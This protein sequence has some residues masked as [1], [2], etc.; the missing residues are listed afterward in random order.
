MSTG[1]AILRETD[2]LP[3]PRRQWAIATIALGLI[4]AVMDSAIANVALPTIAVDLNSEPAHSIWVVNGYQLAI[5]V[6]LLPLSSL[7][8]RIGYRNIYLP[9]LAIFT[10]ASVACALSTSLPMLT[11]ARVIQGF[12]AAGIMSVNTALL[13]YIYPQR[14]LGRGIGINALVVALSAAAGPTIASAILSVANWPWLFAVNLPIGLVAL[15]IGMR[16]LPATPT[17]TH[18]FDYI[19]ALLSAA[20]FGLLIGSIDALAQGEGIGLFIIEMT[21]GIGLAWLLTKREM[22]NPAPVL[23]VDLLRIPI[24]ALSLATSISSFAA[25]MLALVSLPFMLHDLGYDA[26]ETG[27]LITPWPIAIAI[28]APLAGR[29]TEKYPAGLLGGIGLGIFA[30][31][32]L[33]LALIPPQPNAFDI[34]WRM[35]L[36]GA[37][38]GMFQSPNNRAIIMSAPKSRSGGASGM[39]GTARLLG[40]TTGAAMV[41]LLFSRVPVH[42]TAVALLMA[43][44]FAIVA[45]FVSF[46]RLYEGKELQQIRPSNPEADPLMRADILKEQAKSEPPKEP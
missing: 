37:G 7:G 18:K 9:G 39:L 22:G 14:L 2:G 11:L 30:V 15:L 23:P 31:G 27:L 33:S 10:L 1:E 20:T 34:I 42:A 6:A 35:A 3:S 12:G 45:A 32:L 36:C 5:T 13:R 25:Q 17:H 29:L 28:A 44:G 43:T 21:I 16:C 38:F 41:A 8:D 19:S 26:V 4:L 24:F 46:A 40:Q